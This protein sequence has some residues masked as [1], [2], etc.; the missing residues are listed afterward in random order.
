MKSVVV[1]ESAIDAG[2][3]G[4]ALRGAIAYDQSPDILV[5]GGWS[6]AESMARSILLIRQA[7]TALVVDA[8]DTDPARTAERQ[9]FMESSLGAYSGTTAYKV[10]QFVPSI[11]SSLFRQPR[12]VEGVALTQR[13][14][15]RA[16]YEPTQV[17]MEILKHSPR[18]ISEIEKR[19]QPRWDRIRSEPE[20]VELIAFL[21]LERKQAAAIEERL[22]QLN[23]QR[24]QKL[25]SLKEWASE[26]AR[27]ADLSNETASPDHYV[28]ET[29]V[30]ALQ[31]SAGPTGTGRDLQEL[32]GKVIEQLR[33]RIL[34]SQ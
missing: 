11:L 2:I 3:V 4:H 23:A 9:H 31:T 33:A 1:T 32:A 15:F 21:D 30:G 7:P 16:R 26:V 14:R 29:L 12:Y 8:D 22:A 27:L 10:I 13:Q 28:S 25:L 18:S 24:R 5:A 20:F 6:A 19:L 17:L 34:A